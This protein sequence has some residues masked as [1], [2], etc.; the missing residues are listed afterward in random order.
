MAG[1]SAAAVIHPPA[2]TTPIVS[3]N[4]LAEDAF[5]SYLADKPNRY[6]FSL[7]K[8]LDFISWLTDSSRTPTNAFQSKRKFVSHKEY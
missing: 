8:K 6:L 3:F 2:D 1:S 7:E 5:N 4:R